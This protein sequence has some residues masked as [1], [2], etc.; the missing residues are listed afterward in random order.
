MKMGTAPADVVNP[1]YWKWVFGLL[2][3]AIFVPLTFIRKVEKLAATHLFGD[4]MILFTVIVIMVYA[5]IA[6]A[7]RGHYSYTDEV[8]IKI[9]PPLFPNAIGF[10]VFAYEGVG[11]IIPVYEI[12]RDK[13][14]YF[15]LI[16]KVL[17]FICVLYMTFSLNS[18][19]GFGV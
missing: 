7:N 5:F 18:I 14:N 15:N 17:I 12:T 16:V 6:V 8:L 13:E 4:I 2:C 11:I 9:N 1:A 3:F 19:F 10:S